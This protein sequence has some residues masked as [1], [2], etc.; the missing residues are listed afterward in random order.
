M[1]LRAHLTALLATLLLSA[2]PLPASGRDN[3]FAGEQFRRE[4]CLLSWNALMGPLWLEQCL[5]RARGERLPKTDLTGYLARVPDVGEVTFFRAS[6]GELARSEILEVAPA[7]RGFRIVGEMSIDG[8]RI[9]GAEGVVIPGKKSRIFRE[10][11][12]G[13][14]IELKKPMTTRWHRTRPG[15]THR[16]RGGG[17]ATLDGLRLHARYK[18]TVTFRGFE[19]IETPAATY[20]SAVVLDSTL[21]LTFKKRG[22]T[23]KF[24]TEG[25]RWYTLEHGLVATTERL[26]VR[27]GGELLEDPGTIDTWLVDDPGL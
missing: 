12:D 7:K 9:G 21:T 25:T 19:N 6:T 1:T 10:N 17:K 27:S 18:G 3:P 20:E 8:E 16:I 23:L 13:I 26:Q 2:P 15:K 24:L 5:A 14:E 11:I 4:M 22:T